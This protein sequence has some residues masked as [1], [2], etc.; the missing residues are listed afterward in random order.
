[1]KPILFTI[2]AQ[3]ISS[4]G[5]FLMLALLLSIFIIWRIVRVYDLD[6]EKV[7]DLVFLTFIGGI[8]FARIYFVLFHLPEFDSIYKMALINRYPGL[9]FWGGLFGGV[10]ALKLFTHRLKLNFWQMADFAIPGFFLG[11]ATASLGCLLGSC[12]YGLPSDLPFA[13]SQIGILGNRFPIQA[14]ES[15]LFFVGF[16]YFWRATVK[17]H[18]TGKI[19]SIGLVYFGIVKLVLEFFYGSAQAFYATTLGTIYSTILILAGVLFFYRLGKRSFVGDLM[20]IKKLSDAEN[21]KEA[22]L[23]HR[24]NW[25][26]IRVNTIVAIKN[27]HKT[28]LKRINVKDNPSQF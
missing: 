12:Q 10:L 9:S 23:K 11:L 18:F 20:S 1:M 26:N 13:V 19:S 17:F 27:L 21:R 16:L 8:I 24:K 3:P 4:F 6:Q 14:I 25:Y 15:M 22:V 7:L 5:L 28:L 2:G